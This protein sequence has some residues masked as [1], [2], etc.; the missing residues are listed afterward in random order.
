LTVG[1]AIG[2]AL[3]ATTVGVIWMLG[4]Y[5]IVAIGSPMAMWAPLG[6]AVVSAVPEE[7][8]FRGVVFRIADEGIG[9]VGALALSSALFGA[10][11]LANPHATIL[12]SVAIALEAGVLLG[13]AFMCTRRLWLPIGL[14]A[15]WNFTQ[16]GVFGLPVSGRPV[17]GLLTSHVAGPAWVSGG[18]FGVEASLPAAIVCVGAGCVFLGIAWR[19]GLVRPWAWRR[20]EAL[21]AR[22]L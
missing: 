2:T 11:H 14:H 18:A 7:I 21:S 8:L 19:R 9:S 10:A 5:S 13:A 20:Q 22:P 1:L 15:A 6:L 16:A 12:S 4:D 3:F 17:D